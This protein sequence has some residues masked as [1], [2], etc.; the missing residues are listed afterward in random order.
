MVIEFHRSHNLVMI[1]WCENYFAMSQI[2]IIAYR[3]SMI[4]TWGVLIMHDFGGGIEYIIQW[5]RVNRGLLRSVSESGGMHA[6][7]G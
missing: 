4:L 6:L 1:G 5:S 2:I 3:Y 7:V